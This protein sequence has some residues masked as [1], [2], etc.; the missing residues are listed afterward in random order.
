MN[1]AS[2]DSPATM[3][4]DAA[5]MVLYFFTSIIAVVGNVFICA[6]IKKK[7]RLT[8]TT[9]L[10]IFN[11]AISDIIGGSV[12]IGQWFFCW[13]KILDSGRFGE[14]LCWSMKILQVLSYYVS[15][16]TMAA[17]AYD[18]YKLVCRPMEKRFNVKVMLVVIWVAG[19]IFI[20]TATFAVRVSE[21]FSPKVSNK[22]LPFFLEFF[23]SPYAK[24]VFKICFFFLSRHFKHAELYSR[25]QQHWDSENFV[26]HSCF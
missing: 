18:R 25:S 6:T 20:S 3:R 15:S 7:N 8:S 21:Y 24:N 13:T 10:L 23:T 16:L 22:F 2:V 11:M 12:I 14:V 5:I 26:P 19:I 9:Y 1:A 17:I 4:R